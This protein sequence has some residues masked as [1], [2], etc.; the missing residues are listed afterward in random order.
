[1]ER[2]KLEELAK[3]AVKLSKGLEE[4]AGVLR[5]GGLVEEQRVGADVRGEAG[6]IWDLS[7][8][9]RVFA[10]HAVEEFVQCRLDKGERGFGIENGSVVFH[11][12]PFTF[13]KL[14]EHYSTLLEGAPGPDVT[15]AELVGFC[16]A[17]G[18]S[19]ED[20]H[21]F[22]KSYLLRIGVYAGMKFDAAVRHYMNPFGTELK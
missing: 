13:E 19:R 14:N 4:F 17:R 6:E 15:K 7:P 16:R 8:E 1:M 3:I 18:L 11:G 10:V 12:C 2:S 20:A 22:L 5:D 21:K 9:A